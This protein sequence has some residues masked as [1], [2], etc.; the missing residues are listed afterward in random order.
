[1]KTAICMIVKNEEK[2]IAEWIAYHLAIGFNSVI[3]FDNASTDRTPFIIAHFTRR[4][5][6]RRI[7]W[8][9]TNPLYQMQAYDFALKSFRT[10]FDWICFID[11]DEF[12]V[13]LH[14]ILINEFLGSF[15]D[16]SAMAVNWACFGSSGYLTRPKG[17]IIESFLQRSET[18]FAPNRHVKSFVRPVNTIR[19]IN[20][21]YFEVR[22]KYV[23]PHGM[24]VEWASPGI[25]TG[26]PV[27][28]AIQINHYFI[29]SAEQWEE[30]MVR[31]YHDTKRTGSETIFK[32]YDRNE[33]KD[34]AILSFLSTTE[35]I[36]TQT[37]EEEL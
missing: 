10:E 24:L 6:V 5:D 32:N 18:S 11:S 9:V 16:V 36:I 25:T 22:G 17:L 28:D 37:L 13:P 8:K 20:P 26:E 3:L 19:S 29:K 4:Y 23:T 15:P 12:V 14:S 2:S 33:V 31:G 30:K 21:H 34:T 1:M 35:A 27:F 7:N